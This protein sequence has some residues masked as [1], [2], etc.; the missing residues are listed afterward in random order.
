[1]EEGPFF[2]FDPGQR[3]GDL[4]QTVMQFEAGGTERRMAIVGQRAAD[5][6]TIAA[7]GVA[8]FVFSPL[9]CSLNGPH[10]AHQLLQF[11]LGVS[12]RLEDG[13]SRLIQGVIVAELVGHVG[14]TPL[15][16]LSNGLLTIGKNSANRDR[17][18][19][20]DLIQKSGQIPARATEQGSGQEHLARQTITDESRAPRARHPAASHQ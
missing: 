9:Q 15:H 16:S 10:P 20:L 1:M 12:I 14:K 4:S 11:G 8:L 18:C 17:H 7:H 13:S 3:V 6:Q 5:S 2:C 19:C